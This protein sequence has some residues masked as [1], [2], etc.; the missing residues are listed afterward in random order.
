MIHL[1]ST[2]KGFLVFVIVIGFSLI[3]NLLA[4]FVTGSGAY[5]DAHKW[6]FAASLFVSAFVCWFVGRYL[7]YHKARV[8]LDPE[9]GKAVVLKQ[10]HTFFFIPI[11]W[12]CPILAAFSLLA[13][14]MEFLRK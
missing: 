5:W 9:T 12:W 3:A 1:I 2:G 7:Q 8:L 11:V 4:N 13:M 10:S 6:P 14:G